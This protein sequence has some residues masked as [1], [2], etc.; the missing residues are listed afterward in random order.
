[1]ADQFLDLDAE[2]LRELIRWQ[3]TRF[4]WYRAA[5]CPCASVEGTGAES[6]RD[7]SG[8]EFGCLDGF[9]YRPVAVPE[10]IAD[11]LGVVTNYNKMTYS[12]EFGR[13][14]S[15]TANWTS[16]ANEC[17]LSDHD[18]LVHYGG[19]ELAK[20]LVRRG[21]SDFDE[22]SHPCVAS[23]GEVSRGFVDWQAG[24]DFE[25]ERNPQAQWFERAR[26]QWLDGGARPET[27]E[28]YSVSYLRYPRLI[29]LSDSN[30]PARFNHAGA[31][32]V[33][34]GTL[35]ILPLAQENQ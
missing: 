30:R 13:V 19:V 14:P 11:S 20:E 24:T 26:V 25:L 7:L 27:G 29:W 34:R 35:T 22:L 15:G 31:R 21:D 17:E 9:L 18:I 32:L 28:F 8:C 3:G 1:M 16:M 10:A 12:P 23:I 5:L 33:Q 4:D 6:L 2:A